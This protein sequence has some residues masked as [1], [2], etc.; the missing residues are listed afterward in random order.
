MIQFSQAVIDMIGYYR[1]L[2]KDPRNG[3]IF[4][5]G[6]GNG[7]RVFNHAIDAIANPEE[8]DKLTRIRIIRDGGREVQYEILR[9]GLTENEAIQ[10]E[11]AIIDYMGVPALT[12]KYLGHDSTTQGRMTIP[13]IISM[14]NPQPV[15]IQESVLLITPRKLYERNMSEGELYEITRGNWVVGDRRNKAKYAFALRNGVVLQVYNIDRWF[16]V[17]ARS[18]EQKH[19]NRWRFEGEIANDMKNY[20]G[21]S[22]A[23]YITLGSRNPLKYINC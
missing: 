18:L 4:Y 22:V 6:K 5:V 19:Q 7:N 16:R 20:V 15:I 10:V 3:Q 13:E 1:Y 2:L 17:K 12:N 21:K 23:S 8:T 14:Y 11:A 9:H